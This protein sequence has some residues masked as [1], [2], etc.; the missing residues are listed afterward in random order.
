M[1]PF[2]PDFFSLSIIFSEFT[3][4]VACISISFPLMAKYSTVWTYHILFIYL[5]VDGHLSCSHF[6][7]IVTR[8]PWTI[9]C[10]F[11]CRHILISLGY[12]PRSGIAS[13]LWMFCWCS[14]LTSLVDELLACPSLC[15]VRARSWP[16]VPA[17]P[18]LGSCWQLCVCYI[19]H[20]VPGTLSIAHEPAL[21]PASR[22]QGNWGRITNAN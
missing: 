13:V 21:N 11:L 1:W 6:L 2:V 9:A 16:L 15:L 3:H 10:K 4:I 12:K 7:A 19:L 22:P 14:L 17:Q 18:L 8:L 5:S 20:P